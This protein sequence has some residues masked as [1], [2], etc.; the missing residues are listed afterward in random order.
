[1]NLENINNQFYNNTFL[2][3]KNILE[4]LFSH[5]SSNA[6]IICPKIHFLT[7]SNQFSPW[8]GTFT[9][10]AAQDDLTVPPRATAPQSDLS[11]HRLVLTQFYPLSFSSILST[12]L[13]CLGF[14]IS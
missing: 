4:A 7:Q 12:T 6:M 8:L 1:M 2:Y 14:Y 5:P 13:T 10:P 11:S 9:T 3:L